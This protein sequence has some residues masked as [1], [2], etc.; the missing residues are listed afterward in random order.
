M[1]NSE[2]FYTLIELFMNDNKGYIFPWQSEV[3]TIKIINTQPHVR[4]LYPSSHIELK[5]MFFNF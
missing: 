4:C 1:K 5:I 2:M 3:E